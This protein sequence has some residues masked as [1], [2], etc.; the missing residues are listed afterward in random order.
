MTKTL[1]TQIEINASQKEVWKT[2]TNT[3]KF[4]EWNPFITSMKGELKLGNTIEVQLPGMKFKPKIVSIDENKEFKW[5]G[6]LFVKGLFD[7][8]HQFILQKITETKTLF[9]HKEEFK[10]ALVPLFKKMIEGKTKDGFLAMNLA[11][12]KECEKV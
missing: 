4:P 3:N 12:K 11:L 5:L 8:K 2:L 1:D 7:G 10:G 6:H 9:I